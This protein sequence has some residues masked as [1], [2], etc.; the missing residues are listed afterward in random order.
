MA[1]SKKMG[2]MKGMSMKQYGGK[3]KM[4]GDTKPNGVSGSQTIKGLP[5]KKGDRG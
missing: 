5:W 1:K 3:D 2:G 4:P